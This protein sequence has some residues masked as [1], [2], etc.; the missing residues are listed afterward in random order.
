MR[1]YSGPFKCRFVW[2]CWPQRTKANSFLESNQQTENFGRASWGAH[3][4]KKSYFWRGT[5]S[6]HCRARTACQEEGRKEGK[7]RSCS[8]WCRGSCRYVF[9]DACNYFSKYVCRNRW[10]LNYAPNCF[11]KGGKG[12]KEGR[13]GRKKG[14]EGGKKGGKGGKEG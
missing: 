12:R 7:D 3:G 10:W 11:W 13:K 4:D 5:H 9:P 6:P 8:G 2:F 14:F 1:F